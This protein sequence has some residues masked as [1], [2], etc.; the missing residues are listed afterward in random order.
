MRPRRPALALLLCL[1]LS[2]C[3][4]SLE[5]LLRRHDYD[6][7]VCAAMASPEA[8]AR[9]GAAIEEALAP[10][11][12][13]HAITAA[14]LAQAPLPPA[15]LQ[16]YAL[17]RLRYTG[18]RVPLSI[19]NLDLKVSAGAQRLRL[20][21]LRAYPVLASLTGESLPQPRNVVR[22]H[23]AILNAVLL[24]F[25]V[26]ANVVSVPLTGRVTYIDGRRVVV[27]PPDDDD[28]ARAAPRAW[29]L[30]HLLRTEC[31]EHTAGP[32][33]SIIAVERPPD[34]AQAPLEV[35][36][37]LSFGPMLLDSDRPEGPV[38]RLDRAVTARLPPAPTLE[39]R[40]AARF[41]DRLRTFAELRAEASP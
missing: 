36:I 25:V 9:G 29:A 14:E 7:A 26:M 21:D 27:V 17:L 20:L 8:A 6:D 1:P 13:L 41:G 3:A 32:C 38:C 23:T 40:V 5:S 33:D 24:P 12:H 22:D 4:P 31:P 34:E 10:A 30:R 19:F 2:A 18:N 39:E 11:V 15:L 28:F 35:R 37:G 16:R